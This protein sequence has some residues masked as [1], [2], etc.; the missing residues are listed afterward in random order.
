MTAATSGGEPPTAGGNIRLNPAIIQAY[1]IDACGGDVEL[2]LQMV[3][4][5]LNSA[6]KLVAEMRGG[7]A[8]GNMEELRRA[9][10]SLK[11][12]SRM[13]SAD[14]LSGLSAQVEQR[15]KAAETAGIESL[16]GQIQQQLDEL[17]QALPAFCRGML[18]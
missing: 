1:V 3:E 4:F 13:F 12:S 2:V 10:H 16:L 18:A 6:A 7:L 14:D 11:S 15:A 17:S 9:A 5:F 8:S